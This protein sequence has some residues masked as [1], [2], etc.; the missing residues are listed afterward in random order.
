M[1]PE[2]ALTWVIALAVPVWLVVEQL[3][4][5]RP[6]AKERRAQMASARREKSVL[7]PAA[8]LSELPQKAA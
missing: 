5:R 1:A 3:L 4:V 8:L 2:Q 6:S 7:R